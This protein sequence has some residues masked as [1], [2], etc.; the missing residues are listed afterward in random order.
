M[1]VPENVLKK[2][3]GEL[4]ENQK[5]AVKFICDCFDD[6]LDDDGL[7][8]WLANGVGYKPCQLKQVL[9]NKKPNK[10]KS[11][12]ISTDFQEIYNFL[13]DNSINSN[14]SAYSMNRINKRFFLEEF[15]NI[16]DT[17]VIEKRVQLKNGS[18]F[19]FKFL[20]KVYTGLLDNF[21]QV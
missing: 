3:K 9:K 10:R 6:M 11:K 7:I 14:E 21:L 8:A 4:N 13:L 16:N 18:K 1:N 17:N 15:S 20:P 2:L 19:V 5:E 12:F